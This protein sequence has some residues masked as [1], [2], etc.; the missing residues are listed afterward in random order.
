MLHASEA[1]A[2]LENSGRDAGFT[3]QPIEHMLGE[4]AGTGPEQLFNATR[5]ALLGTYQA[6]LFWGIMTS[7]MR[8]ER[9]AP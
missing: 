3:D 6:G 9:S 4:T 5:R 2:E 7:A 1:V 8:S